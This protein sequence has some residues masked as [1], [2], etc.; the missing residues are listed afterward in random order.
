MPCGD[1]SWSLAKSVN[2]MLAGNKFILHSIYVLYKLNIYRECLSI[3]LLVPFFMPNIE[4]KTGKGV[5]PH[6]LF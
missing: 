3:E 5:S 4:E 1:G 2:G 6:I